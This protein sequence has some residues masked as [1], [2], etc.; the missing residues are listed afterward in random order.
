MRKIYSLTDTID[1][2][3]H[4]LCVYVKKAGCQTVYSQLPEQITNE[5]TFQAFRKYVERHA[6]PRTESTAP[7]RTQRNRKTMCLA[8]TINDILIAAVLKVLSRTQKT[9]EFSKFFDSA[10]LDPVENTQNQDIYAALQDLTSKIDMLIQKQNKE[11]QKVKR[12][13]THLS[14][15]AQGYISAFYYITCSCSD[16]VYNPSYSFAPFIPFYY[17]QKIVPDSSPF[18]SMFSPFQP[19]DHIQYIKTYRWIS[20]LL[21]QQC[22]CLFRGVTRCIVKFIHNTNFILKYQNNANRTACII[23][24]CMIIYVLLNE[25]SLLLKTYPSSFNSEGPT[26]QIEIFKQSLEKTQ[27]AIKYMIEYFI[28]NSEDDISEKSFHQSNKFLLAFVHIFASSSLGIA[29]SAQQQPWQKQTGNTVNMRS[30]GQQTP[31]FLITP[32]L[33]KALEQL[34]QWT[35]EIKQGGYHENKS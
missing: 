23:Q 21:I 9:I 22:T 27:E 32:T 7:I 29:Y 30:M 25:T 10:E 35:L 6:Q 28:D 12:R 3:T 5:I 34:S 8:F 2:A 1:K 11:A 15:I 18:Y 26:L 16:F 31:L 4:D 24:N 13:F 33:F 17:E 20:N 19:Y 14:V